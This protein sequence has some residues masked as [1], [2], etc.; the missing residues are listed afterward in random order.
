MRIR[1]RPLDEIGL[2]I[3]PLCDVVFLILTFFMLTAQLA[4]RERAMPIH[5]P[6]APAAA[7]TPGDAAEPRFIINLDAHGHF[8]AGNDPIDAPELRRRL[9]ERF[10]DKPPLKVH[11]RADAATPAR[12]IKQ[13]I[14][15]SAEA[16]A[17]EVILGA[18][19]DA[20]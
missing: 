13:A 1:R 7:P 14:A 19:T 2:Q 15:W 6:T 3:A 18:T 11:L 4:N 8:Y 9:R 17:I 12:A 5:L 20:P 10:R 16:G